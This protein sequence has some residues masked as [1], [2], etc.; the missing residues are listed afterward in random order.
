[1]PLSGC[2]N[3][4]S[5]AVFALV[6]PVRVKHLTLVVQLSYTHTYG[7]TSPYQ[8]AHCGNCHD[9]IAFLILHLITHFAEETFLLLPTTTCP[10]RKPTLTKEAS[11]L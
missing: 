9:L 3:P 11:I 10:V 6:D 1:M 7:H 2:F 5:D 4:I 8:T